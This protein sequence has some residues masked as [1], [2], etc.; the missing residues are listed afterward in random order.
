MWGLVGKR[1]YG[2]DNSEPHC[3]VLPKKDKPLGSV[4]RLPLPGPSWDLS[5]REK[6]RKSKGKLQ[7][8][9][10]SFTF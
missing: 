4:G 7:G 9:K 1:D 6:T 10:K 3:P 8:L 2:H 5:F